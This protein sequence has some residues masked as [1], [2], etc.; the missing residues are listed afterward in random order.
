[1]IAG[2][3]SAQNARAVASKSLPP[4]ES[5]AQVLSGIARIDFQHL[6]VHK[7]KRRNMRL[8]PLGNDHKRTTPHETQVVLLCAPH[9]RSMQVGVI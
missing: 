9:E 7:I 5:Q 4:F 8:Y 3:T 1:M 6:S 2:P